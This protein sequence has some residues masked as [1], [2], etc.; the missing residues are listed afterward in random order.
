MKWKESEI[1]VELSDKL[2]VSMQNPKRYEHKIIELID[3][4]EQEKNGKGKTQ[5]LKDQPTDVFI[6][7]CWANSH[8]A[9]EKGI[10]IIGIYILQYA[11]I[12]VFY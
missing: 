1:G 11:I 9:I 5:Q 7:Y 2:Y 6:S 8:D 3:L 10:Q 4:I 12:F